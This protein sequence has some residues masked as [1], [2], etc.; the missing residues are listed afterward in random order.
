MANVC[1]LPP[2]CPIMHSSFGCDCHQGWG[3]VFANIS[4]W[5]G[6]T[7][8]VY[9]IVGPQWKLED[10]IWSSLAC[11]EQAPHNKCMVVLGV[12][13]GWEGRGGGE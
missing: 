8:C 6:T 12:N 2:T 10:I 7:L 11:C 4:L 13:K 5:G 9:C 3:R 1:V